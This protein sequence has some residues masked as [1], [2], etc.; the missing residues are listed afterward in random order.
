MS[1]NDR[2]NHKDGNDSSIAPYQVCSFL[3]HDDVYLQLLHYQEL[4]VFDQVAYRLSH[5]LLELSQ[6]LCHIY[7]CLYK[8]G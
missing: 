7:T 5:K 4:E 8:H 6:L 1:P 2:Y 3:T